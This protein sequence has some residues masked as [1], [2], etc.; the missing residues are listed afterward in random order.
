MSVFEHFERIRIINL[1]NR[2]DRRRAMDRE[3][4]KVGLSKCS[5]VGYFNAIRPANAGTFTSTGAHGV[6]LSHRALLREAADN[7]VSLLILEDDC[8]F[9]ADAVASALVGDWDIFYG[10][11]RAASPDNLQ[12][13]DIE[14]AHMMG[15]TARSVRQISRYLEALEPDGIHPPIDGAYVWFRRE[16]P[17]VRTIFATPQMA[18]QRSSRS[19]IAD[20]AWFDRI[21]IVREG[22]SLARAI[23]NARRN[24]PLLFL[25]S[26]SL[27]SIQSVSP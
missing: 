19:D 16:N 23:L 12:Q 4:K 8:S 5:R 17:E 15:F 27:L 13:S 6:Y 3:L 25:I 24:V 9:N 14:C 10:G 11:Y 18:Y 22:A 2:T 26:W 7:G 1:P 21:P 20:L